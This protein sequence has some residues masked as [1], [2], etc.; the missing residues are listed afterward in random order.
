MNLGVSNT[1]LTRVIASNPQFTGT[2]G[3]FDRRVL[4]QLVQSIGYTE[5]DYIMNQRKQLI[6]AQLAQAFG[7]GVVAPAAYLRAVHDY[8][9]E[10]R[11]ISYFVLTASP[12]RILRS[13]SSFSAKS[14]S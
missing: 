14:S 11:D 2:G 8:Q 12:A 6:R 10:E 5:D 3:V 1:E 9:S 7:G 13:R 4:Q